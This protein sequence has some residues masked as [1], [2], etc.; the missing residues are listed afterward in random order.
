MSLGKTGSFVHTLICTAA[1]GFSII[2]GGCDSSSSSTSFVI[3]DKNSLNGDDIYYNEL[4]A[5]HFYL[6][7]L[8]YNANIKNELNQNVNVYYGINF[9]ADFTKGACTAYFADVC[10]MYNQMSDKFTRYFDPFYA[11]QV[12]NSLNETESVIG[13]G[14]EVESI[15]KDDDKFLVIT[16]VYKSGPAEKI[17]SV[18]D[19]IISVNGDIPKTE[20]GFKKLTTFSSPE[21]VDITIRNDNGEKTVSVKA[22]TYF[23][24]SVHLKY[25]DSIPVIKIDE[26][27]PQT[28]DDHGTYAEFLNAIK[29]VTENGDKS[30][31]IDLRNNPG[32]DMDH[33]V[34]IASE[35]LSQGDTIITEISTI[36]DS[37]WRNG[38][39][40]IIQAFDT[41][42]Y[43]A[44]TKGIGE[45]LYYVF[46]ANE[47]SASCSE[48]LLSAVTIN[49]NTPVIGATSY[50][51]GI[52]QYYFTTFA[53]GL[54]AITGIHMQDKNGDSYHSFGIKPDYEISDS[55]EQMEKALALAKERKEKRTAGY[56]TKSTGNFDKIM[57]KG[58]ILENFR[59][60]KGS[61]RFIN[62]KK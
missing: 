24:P 28:I 22:D 43:T 26:F 54:A 7:V 34:N 37:V 21:T 8:Y 5:N 1:L 29:N 62:M 25:I 12:I 51:K 61:Y 30:A 9:E 16:E 44:T 10:G 59:L 36:E 13:I 6:S 31:I 60:D 14:V 40:E 18:G 48:I 2:V 45:G 56:G 41:I 11:S 39:F 46:L 55:K 23:S 17:L 38:H 47:M 52:G 42:T 53:K 4:A 35:L 19:T 49:K 50:G 15:S 3:P 27:T 32:G 20:D 57:A 58:G 33:C